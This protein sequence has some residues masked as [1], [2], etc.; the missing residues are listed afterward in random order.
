MSKSSSVH[1]GSR[2]GVVLAVS[3]RD[4]FKP[5]ALMLP[6]LVLGTPTKSLAK[7]DLEESAR[8]KELWKQRAEEA[9]RIFKE[10]GHLEV[11]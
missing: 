5:I 10:T 4:V 11:A 2:T 7:V 6:A 3:R 9:K 1:T 8:R